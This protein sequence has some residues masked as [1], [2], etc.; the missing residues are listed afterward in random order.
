MFSAIL[1]QRTPI[2]LAQVAAFICCLGGH[3][4]AY[5][6][7]DGVSL[8]DQ[9]DQRRVFETTSFI[10]H[11]FK[12]DTSGDWATTMEEMDTYFSDMFYA[13]DADRDGIVSVSE[14]PRLLLQIRLMG[15]PF[16]AEGLDL[17]ELRYRLDET[18]Q[19]LDK[20]NNGKLGWIEML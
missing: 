8:E 12:M 7:Y 9:A 5:A 15:K 13:F 19:F 10:N 11:F 4:V 20:N 17:D 6:Q 2:L 14:A 16:P 18:F 1:Q 3:A